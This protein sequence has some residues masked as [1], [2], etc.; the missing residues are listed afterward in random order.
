MIDESKLRALIVDAVR[1]VFAEREPRPLPL[2]SRMYVTL[3]EAAAFTGLSVATISRAVKSGSLPAAKRKRAVR[4]ARA[5]LD[6]W[7]RS[8]ASAPG[9]VVNVAEYARKVRARAEKP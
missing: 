9:T 2:E 7:M 4:I 5:D 1:S 3:R 8:N 6:T